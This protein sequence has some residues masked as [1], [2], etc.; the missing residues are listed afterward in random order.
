MA[1]VATALAFERRMSVEFITSSF[2][3]VEGSGAM[4]GLERERVMVEGGDFFDIF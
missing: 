1:S 3:L 2:S 4:L